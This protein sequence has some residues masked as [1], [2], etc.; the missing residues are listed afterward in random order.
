MRRT[1]SSAFTMTSGE[2]PELQIPDKR[3]EMD[4]L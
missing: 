4:K 2:A 3:V 1:I